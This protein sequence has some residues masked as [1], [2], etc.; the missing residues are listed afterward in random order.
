MFDN[1][2]ITY[3]MYDELEFSNVYTF[4]N[5]NDDKHYGFYKFLYNSDMSRRNV[6]LHITRNGTESILVNAHDRVKDYF[7]YT[8]E[9]K[10][11]NVLLIERP[12]IY[13]GFDKINIDD[14]NLIPVNPDDVC[15]YDQRAVVFRNK[16]TNVLW[17]V[18]RANSYYYSLGYLFFLSRVKERK[19]NY[20]C[21]TKEQFISDFN[22]TLYT[23]YLLKDD[24]DVR[25]T[26]K[27]HR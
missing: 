3:E 1:D 16:I 7:G 4:I 17:L 5:K 20:V 8:D 13:L 11:N 24:V 18:H 19:T 25:F 23:P 21:Y 26:I 6:F 9:N 10:R 27:L 14:N 2:I 12:Y 15:L 22:T